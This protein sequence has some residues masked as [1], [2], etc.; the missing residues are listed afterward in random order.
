MRRRDPESTKRGGSLERARCLESSRGAETPSLPV[1]A[2]VI[3]WV[4]L[5]PIRL[6]A[7][8]FPTALGAVELSAFVA[9]VPPV[10]WMIQ[11]AF[12]VA[13]TAAIES[14]WTRRPIRSRPEGFH[15]GRS[16]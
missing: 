11:V 12:A 5:L 6:G 15:H 4:L 13:Q 7:F 10:L 2:G 8:L 16:P 14:A 1:V 3:V 9:A